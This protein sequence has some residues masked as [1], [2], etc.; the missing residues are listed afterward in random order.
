M[1][2]HISIDRTKRLRKEPRKGHNRWYPDIPPVIEVEPGVD[3]T[4]E[5]R[6]AMDLQIGQR[7]T[8]KDLE[9]LERKVAHPLTGPVWVKGAKPGDLLEI[10][11]L[12]IVPDGRASRRAS[13]SCRTFS[14]TT[15]WRTGTSC[16]T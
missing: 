5:T 3:V 16:R 7:T 13:G 15:S 2:R 8:A 11:H 14:T 1:A 12:D 10:E 9:K 6:D 4:L